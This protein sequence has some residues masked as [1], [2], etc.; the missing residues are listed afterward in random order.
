MYKLYH[1]WR[2]ALMACVDRMID[3]GLAVRAQVQQSGFFQFGLIVSE[4]KLLARL[5]LAIVRNIVPVSSQQ[6]TKTFILSCILGIGA[7]LLP[8]VLS[9]ANPGTVIGNTASAAYNIGVTPYTAN[10]NNVNVTTAF[11]ASS[12][13]FYQ[14]QPGATATLT[15]PTSCA[16]G[17]ATGPFIPS[18]NPTDAGGST[19][20]TTVPVDL[21]TATSF[22]PN[23]TLFVRLQDMNSNLDPSLRDIIT[24]TLTDS[25]TGDIEVI[26]M[27]ET[28]NSTGSF[29]GY[30]QSTTTAS[31][32]Y[33]CQLS[34]AAGSTVTVTYTDPF[35]GTDISI[36]NATITA[37]SNNTL[38]VNKQVSDA[39]ASVGDF[40]RYTITATNL[41]TASSSLSTV[42]TD[43]LPVGFRYRTGSARL[44]GLTIADPVVGAN[45]RSLIFD[46]G[47]IA[48]SSSVKL[49]YI[50]EVTAGTP[51]GRAYN[52]ATASN[53]AGAGSNIARVA[54]KVEEDLFHN[55]SRIV[56]RVT[57]GSCESE[58][59]VDGD[60]TMR[61]QSRLN[62]SIIHY[63]LNL[64][65][66]K[67]PVTDLELQANMPAGLEYIP[68]S[69]MDPT[70]KAIVS[71]RQDGIVWFR[72]GN[73]TGNWKQTLHFKAVAS[74]GDL[75]LHVTRVVATFNTQA[76]KGNRL[77]ADNTLKRQQS[78]VENRSYIVVPTFQTNSV[79]LNNTDTVELDGLIVQLRGQD[80]QSIRV[81]GHTDAVA[82]S[83]ANKK[84]YND[85]HALSLARAKSV[86]NYLMKALQLRGSQIKLEGYGPDR[87]IADNADVRVRGKN[88][89][90]EID[91]TVLERD[92]TKRLTLLHADSG[93]RRS[94][95]R[96]TVADYTEFASMEN[97]VPGVRLV[98]EDGT[99]VVT[100]KYGQYHLEG[101]Q[102]GTHVIQIDEES[103]PD[104]L[105][106]FICEGNTRFAG[107]PG[108]QF[109][110]TRG[111]T[112]WRANFHL[113]PKL[114]IAGDAGLRMQSAMKDKLIDVRIDMSGRQFSYKN[115]RLHVI[116]PDGL[117]Y[118]A[119][120]STLDGRVLPN[121]GRN[122][123]SLIYP[124]GGISSESWNR[125]LR[126][127]LRY[128][129]G[130]DS[131]I[132][133]RSKMEF[134]AAGKRYST[135][136]IKN[137][138]LNFES[139][140]RYQ[141]YTF[142][143]RSDVLA[144]DLSAYDKAQLDKI[145]D[146]LRSHDI[147]RLQ[148]MG[149]TDN[150]PLSRASRRTY[151]NNTGL[152]RARA[153]KVA[154]YVTN[155][156]KLNSDQMVIIGMG[157]G[158]PIADNATKQGRSLN[159]RVEISVG[160]VD[161]DAPRVLMLVR[162]D[163]AP[164]FNSGQYT[165]DETDKKRLDDIVRRL[166]DQKI[167]QLRIVGHSDSR[168][169]TRKEKHLYK[170]N[171]SLS[172]ARARSMGDYLT[173]ALN[174]PND[175]V[176]TI[177][178]GP[179][180]PV[181]DNSTKVGQSLNRRVELFV[182][183]NEGDPYR[184]QRLL[185]DDSGEKS[186]RVNSSTNSNYG[187]DTQE[188]ATVV[189]D[190][191][192]YDLGWLQSASTNLEFVFPKEGFV[193][194]IPVT[195]IV[196]KHHPSMKVVLKR[197][198]EKVSPLNFEGMLKR[199]DGKI[200]ISRWRSIPLDEG[201]NRIEAVIMDITGQQ[202]DSLSRNIHFANAIA[203]FEFVS[204][205]SQLVADG[206]NPIR[207]AVR[208]L[209]REGYPIRAGVVGEYRV[210]GPHTAKQAL[211]VLQNRV[212]SGMDRQKPNFRIGEDGIAYLELS[213]TTRTGTANVQIKLSNSEMKDLQV[214]LT[215]AQ[216]DWIMVGLA[217]GTLGY[218]T[219]SGNM[220]AAQA[221]EHEDE[222]YTDG[223]LAFY[224][225]GSI[226]GKW[227]LT[228]AYDS[229]R[230]QT[231]QGN[232]VHQLIDPEKYYTLYGDASQ[233]R[234]D[235]A[236]T[237]KL[238]VKLER[239]QFYVLFGDYDTGMTVT[240]LSR[241]S[242]TLTGIKTEYRN[243]IYD[244]NAFIAET[245]QRFV[246]DEIRGEG[247]S[248]LYRLSNKDIVINSDK[249]TI[250]TRDR[251]QSQIVLSSRI[252]SRYV[253][254]SIDP[255][256]GTIYFREPIFSKDADFNPIYIVVDYETIATSDTGITAGARGALR[257]ANKKAEIGV[258]IIHEGVD[259]EEGDLF[260]ADVKY[261]LTKNIEVKAEIATS[262]K[263]SGG[264]ERSGDA[265]L[266]ELNHISKRLEA[267]AYAREQQ[268]GFGVGQQKGTEDGTQ[269]VG[270]EVA[271]KS[272]K[273][274][275]LNGQFWH[276]EN[277][278][279]TATRDVFNAN[280]T[281][282]QSNYSLMGGFRHAQDTDSL[283]IDH[284]SNLVTAGAGR[285]LFGRKVKLRATS[286]IAVGDNENPDFPTRFILGADYNFW[287]RG[288]VF[289]EQELTRG[290]NQDT[291]TT[292]VGMGSALWTGAR[293]N[294]SVQNE[295][296]EYGPR[297]FANMGLTQ[298]ININKNLGVDF[299]FDRS[300]TF[301]DPGDTPFNVNVPPASGTV[302]NDFT[303]YT[304]GLTYRQ[305]LW[306]ATSR[307][308]HRLSELE[309]KDSVLF[310]FY[311]QQSTALGIATRIKYFDTDRSDG[312]VDTEGDVRL[313]LAYRPLQ[314]R[315]IMLNRLDYSFDDS[316][317]LTGTIK[318]RK[319]VD[320]FSGNYQMSRRS[321]L[322]L[323]L[324][325]KHVLDTFDGD[326][327][328]GNTYLLGTEY[329]HDISGRWDY[330]AHA[331]TLYSVDADNSVYSWGL[332]T[333]WSPARNMWISVGYNV[334]GYEDSDF[335]AAG[336]T[337]KGP[338]VKFRFALDYQTSRDFMAWWEKDRKSTSGPELRP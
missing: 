205:K 152:S 226:Q 200:A 210:N 36:A 247:I 237:K 274:V 3:T 229:N 307:V 148:V 285:F 85:N 13:A 207:I 211:D 147:K 296:N 184:L 137:T 63:T 261:K 249:V 8:P 23:S 271:F 193:P 257:T 337:A 53:A 110:D 331:S 301:R 22:V 218:N 335:T 171:Y 155:A 240:E 119:G 278:T 202:F 180:S 161:G 41:D 221:H 69:V 67:V 197:N 48:V 44:D 309:D 224:A 332:S 142:R 318:Q 252:L 326:E 275:T 159:R 227:L 145:I 284:E 259:G 198:G 168:E 28:A 102:P 34:V 190:D 170:D 232:T 24:V 216:R 109:V 242:R 54:V 322:A 121:P 112:L 14:Y 260:G 298:G 32:N 116:L 139:E 289:V 17:A 76:A 79:S 91:I 213:P 178:M 183:V 43:V 323:Q 38:M 293:V 244:V 144:G 106:P 208:M 280:A 21:A 39:S 72:L 251:F 87:P 105:E 6:K 113:R 114:V 334:D 312:T 265:Y 192:V 279:T 104:N 167:Q 330:G 262:E 231:R 250:E 206:K 49:T 270:A 163:K 138:L 328:E 61:L 126:L 176:E 194:P 146:Q 169:L 238:Y 305:T 300:K 314:S 228:A 157:S 186:I 327:Y 212:L 241:Y 191:P 130:K 84:R 140:L 164:K 166:N 199:K 263:T 179:A 46:V 196:V 107:S 239:E 267:K 329:R 18:G 243:E 51:L 10:S 266:A 269:K 308:E 81:S 235:A 195:N 282:N 29:Y 273:H 320:N 134:Y 64:A 11:T 15:S 45:G 222:L 30:M 19:I 338:Y 175:V 68:G 2:V 96:G 62:G 71:Y 47:T 254:Y 101:M 299:G 291:E 103:L 181:A 123:S 99:Y 42:V 215:P 86:G 317:T 258:S 108:S 57:T 294:T 124:L 297:T 203:K 290:E 122:G 283:G 333:G 89:R 319:V 132:V 246:K 172:E 56:G 255:V 135:P 295:M 127:Q 281:Y 325:F 66:S 131:E 303:A 95:T 83:A 189:V 55:Q 143:P 129:E 156:L 230:S 60:I 31:A 160:T 78:Q 219:L 94:E 233:Q 316:E 141:K 287:A 311:R 151:S 133:F 245:D 302:D 115:L 12:I 154:D 93:I 165:L 5:L 248:G 74:E 100:D 20:D 4:M 117:T 98:T 268:P 286:E 225:K 313:S 264:V 70:G 204:E 136:D 177:G 150:T 304:A 16:N 111:G 256:E 118:V 220:Q 128:D 88:R 65:G 27:S 125:I 209:D 37:A 80:I 33:D 92:A 182:S 1:L 25:T 50:T 158:K 59:T 75:G 26:Q 321:Q 97:G 292:R 288:K 223:R 9:A 253:D 234:Y 173:K 153:K 90:V 35:D 82:I 236:S 276:E 174:L 336:Y 7:V 187:V 40:T 58:S 306:S 162:N 272:S 277:L 324:G 310:G 217:E 73:K 52:T 315:W 214:W 149:H 201:D 188:S 120:S 185:R 77:V